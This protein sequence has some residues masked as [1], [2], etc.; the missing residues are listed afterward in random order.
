MLLG[1]F[2]VVEVG[3]VDTFKP[4]IGNESLKEI[5]DGNG[6]RVATFVT[7]RNMTVK[8]TMF[9]HRNIHKCTSIWTS[10]DGK[11]YNQINHILIDGRRHSSVLDVRSFR[12]ADCDTDHYLLV[13]NV[14]ERPAVSKQTTHTVHTQRFNLKKLNEIESKQHYR[15]EISN[16]FAALENLDTGVNINRVWETIRENTNISAKES[17]TV[18][19]PRV[20][21]CHALGTTCN[22]CLSL[23]MSGLWASLLIVF[24]FFPFAAHLRCDPGH[25]H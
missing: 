6:V 23:F 5:S 14:R 16:R 24:P 10:P 20:S 15:V 12:A 18:H 11:I 19:S 7:S 13:A 8:S 22:H 9:T 4:T 25:L 21:L 3:M 2:N 17:I 1:D